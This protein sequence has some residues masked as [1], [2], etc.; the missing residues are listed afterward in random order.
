[1][2]SRINNHKINSLIWQDIYL[3][4]SVN[5]WQPQTIWYYSCEYLRILTKCAFT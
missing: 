5:K 3:N 4:K 1:V 2:T